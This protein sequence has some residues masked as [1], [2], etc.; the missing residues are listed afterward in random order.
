MANDSKKNGSSLNSPFSNKSKANKNSS[1]NNDESPIKKIRDLTRRIRLIEERMES[2][3]KKSQLIE[4]NMLRNNKNFKSEVSHIKEENV[5]LKLKIRDINDNIN[6]IVKELKSAPKKEDV[7]ELKKYVS[8]W[9]P[10]NFITEKD[11]EN[12]L[13]WK[14][15]EIINKKLSNFKQ[16]GEK[17]ASE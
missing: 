7:E 11:V 14:V 6:L 9:E 15:E 4:D 2:L 8:I 3:R 1:N 13:E 16:K 17:N 10:I 12:I 5:N